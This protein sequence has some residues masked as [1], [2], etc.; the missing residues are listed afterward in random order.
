MSACRSVELQP[1]LRFTEVAEAVNSELIDRSV[2][3]LR[4]ADEISRTLSEATGPR[5]LAE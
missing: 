4:H 3:R 1:V 5:R 2:A